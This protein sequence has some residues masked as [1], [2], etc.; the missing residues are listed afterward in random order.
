MRPVILSVCVSGN[1][2]LLELNGSIVFIPRARVRNSCGRVEKLAWGTVKF[3]LWHLS[4]YYPFECMDANTKYTA[5]TQLAHGHTH[6]H[7]IT[8]QVSEREDR[9]CQFF[10]SSW[11]SS[12]HHSLFT[13]YTYA[14]FLDSICLSQLVTQPVSQLGNLPDNEACCQWH[15]LRLL[16]IFVSPLR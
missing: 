10:L 5:Y 14:Y 15:L 4:P 6:I 16:V 8:S 2:V 7:L 12:L 1:R 11:G 13:F 3:I 9:Y